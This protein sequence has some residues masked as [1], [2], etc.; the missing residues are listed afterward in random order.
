L[1][2]QQF[3]EIGVKRVF[4]IIE[5]QHCVSKIVHRASGNPT[6]TARKRNAPAPHGRWGVAGTAARRSGSEPKSG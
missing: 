1:E 2:L 5:S 6:R 3:A 4:E